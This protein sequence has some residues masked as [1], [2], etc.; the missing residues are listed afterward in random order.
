MSLLPFMASRPLSVGVELE[1]QIVNTQ[2]FN[3]ATEAKDL[4]R[5]L[6]K[7]PPHGGEFKPEITQSMI[8][9]NSSVH[10]D[11]AGL[12]QELRAMRDLIVN[13]ARRM[14][15]GVCGG[16]SHPFQK[17]SDRRIYPAERFNALLEKYGYLAKQFTVFGQHIHIGCE[18]GDDAMY[19]AHAFG[20]YIPQLVA[21]SAASPYFQGEDTGFDSCRL[22]VISAFPLSGVLPF[23]HTWEEFVAFFANMVELKVVES[24]KDFYW[25]IRPKPEFG[26]VE[27]RVCDTPLAVE[28]AAMLAGYAQALARYLL[29]ERPFTISPDQYLLYNINRFHAC[30]HGLSGNFI[31]PYSRQH[32]S[33]GA[34]IL[35]TLRTL[36]P[37]AAALRCSEALAAAMNQVTANRND[38]ARLRSGFARRESLND[39]VREQCAFWMR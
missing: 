29:S 22:T 27:I 5:G 23:A 16:G 4:L 30:R 3:L 38:A 8:E 25:D 7:L 19:L 2:N 9:V 35:A 39:V 28:T 37:H 21:L 10:E 24:M 36:E 32:R 34:D 15:V 17:W 18:H 26:T 13:E 33:I 12:L 20:R 1:L 14:N 31:D 6:A 11:Y